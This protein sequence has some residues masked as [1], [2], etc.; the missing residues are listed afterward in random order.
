[1]R[2]LLQVPEGLK[3]KSVELVKE[4]ESK[5]AQ[6]FFSA[7]PCWGACDIKVDEAKRLR[8]DKIVHIAHTKFVDVDFPVEYAEMRAA[9]DVKPAL[10]KDYEKL[11]Q[12]KNIGLISSLQFLDALPITKNFLESKGHK[13]L[14]GNT[15]Y[16]KSQKH[17]YPG[18]VLGCDVTAAQSIEKQ[19]DCFLYVGS[20]RFHALGA[21]LRANK[22]IFALNVEKDRIEKIDDTLFQKQK[23]ATIGLAKDAK[24]FGILI[25]TKIGQKE[26]QGSAISLK[27][28]IESEG[29]QAILIVADEIAQ[30][31]L[32]GI[33]VDAYISTACPRIA[34]ENRAQFSKPILNVEELEEALK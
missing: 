5:G 1:M 20:G 3:K 24:K 28:K 25:S 19:V 13:V 2:I 16:R 34:V 9:A 27:N 15:A 7:E 6:V 11:S 12:Y 21:L 23:Y 31:K 10:E 26:M 8:C 18:Q 33:D 32:L 30:E 22:P 17:L 4:L 14:I 29:K